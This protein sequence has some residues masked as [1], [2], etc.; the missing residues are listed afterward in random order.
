MDLHVRK[1]TWRTGSCPADDLPRSAR[2]SE[3]RGSI[4]VRPARGVDRRRD[5][6]SCHGVAL[7]DRRT[8][9]IGRLAGS[10]LGADVAHRKQREYVQDDA[11]PHQDR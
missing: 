3:F 4:D 8:A 11:E 7:L 2:F 9:E 5:D 1:Q 6:W 10:I